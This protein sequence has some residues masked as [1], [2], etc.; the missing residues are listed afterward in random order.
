MYKNVSVCFLVVEIYFSLVKYIC[1]YA[2]DFWVGV[3]IYNKNLIQ[4]YFNSAVSM[5]VSN[6]YSC[7]IFK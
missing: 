7:V 6:L 3:Y 1:V 5:D 4:I 2:L